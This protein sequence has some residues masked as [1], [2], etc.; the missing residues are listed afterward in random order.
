MALSDLEA[1]D[2]DGTLRA[3]L[4]ANGALDDGSI[5][6]EDEQRLLYSALE[7]NGNPVTLDVMP[8]STHTMLTAD[9]W[10]IFLDA[11]EQAATAG[12]GS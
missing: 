9:G 6:W 3:F 4:E 10:E 5:S 1:R 2:P 8:G 7:A 12:A 11:F